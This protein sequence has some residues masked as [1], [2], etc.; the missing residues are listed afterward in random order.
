MAC[1]IYY[2]NLFFCVQ[3][4]S[5]FNIKEYYV[6][7]GDIDINI[8]NILTKIED[9]KD[10][11]KEEVIILKNNYK[12]Y[13][14]DWIEIT[15]KKYKIKFIANRIHI[16]DTIS[17]IREKIFV[18]LSDEKTKSFILPQNQELFLEKK[19]GSMELIGYYYEDKDTHEKIFK[20]PHINNKGNLIELK[21]NL[22]KNIKKNI[23]KN[24]S[25]N[26]MLIYDLLQSGNYNNKIIY[27]SDAK[28]EEKYLK[29]KNIIINEELIN[30][31]FSIFWPYLNLYYN[32]NEIKNNY[33][34]LKDYY[35][36]ENFIFNYI[37]N[38]NNIKNIKN[39]NIFGSCNILTI[40]LN[41]NKDIN[42]NN[43]TKEKYIDLFPIFD[44][45]RE[46]KIS[47]KTPFI[48]YSENLLDTPFTVISR[49]AIDKKLIKKDKLKEWIGVNDDY[50]K[51]TG[52]LIK[53]LFKTSN[54]EPNYSSYI[55]TKNGKINIRIG[56]LNENNAN[57]NDIV[58]CIKD[59]KSLIE[60]INKKIVTM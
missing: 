8:K 60:D 6:F 29:S 23:K 57:F 27:L 41:I 16:D 43:D 21:K 33:L 32:E 35:T 1:N 22:I 37:N 18:Y 58:D 15:R 25:E 12:D 2:E 55:L 52:L 4:I 14:L 26:S 10:I 28:D 3:K 44:Y 24:T 19:D 47:E 36:K 50:R 45:L 49:D 31:Y 20:E 9:R 54:N 39:N 46:N 38:I 17:N 11:K 59:C 5:N 56:F 53:R 51:M 7:I 42:D 48:K 13:Y 40:Q 34:L 30:N